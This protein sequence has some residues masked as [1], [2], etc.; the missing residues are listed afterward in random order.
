M[1]RLHWIALCIGLVCLLVSAL[2]ASAGTD[3]QV[4]RA[5]NDLTIVV[6][7]NT[8]NRIVAVSV[9]VDAGSKYD[10]PGRR[11][12]AR[13]T[14]ELLVYGTRDMSGSE[15]SEVIDASGVQLGTR[16]T[17]DYA[18]I[19]VTALDSQFDLALKVL[20][21]VVQRPTFDKD[22]VLLAQRLA[23][24][25]L[26]R[27]L[28]DPFARTYMKLNEVLARGHPYASPVI[29]TREGIDAITRKDVALFHA[30]RYSASGTVVAA[31]GN[32]LADEAVKRIADLFSEYPKSDRRG[33]RFPSLERAESATFE[34]HKA[35]P[36]GYLQLGFLAPALGA[37]DYA[38][39]RVLGAVLGDGAA[40]RLYTS[41][42]VDGAGLS[43]VVGA[44]YPG[45]K[46]AGRMVVYA[47]TNQVDLT[48]DILERE[49][50][51][52]RVERVSDEEL[53]RA[54]SRLMARRVLAEQRNLERA[55]RLARD[56][57][58]GLGVGFGDAHVRD[59][60]RV[61]ADDVLRVAQE[62][63]TSPVKV[64]LRPGSRGKKGI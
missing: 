6:S 55:R 11:G 9:L 4:H 16:T 30:E 13:L 50:E 1:K 42:G 39:V 5:D 10:P 23:R 45:R 14:N 47:A 22:A 62:Y 44:F 48:L 52:L 12:L 32:V 20:A 54:Q 26:E 61:D 36:Q 7:P 8:W 60:K 51:K 34:F 35:A 46:E 33:V 19:Y 56:V 24:E 21:D 64:L 18:E 2:S 31:V 40:S 57:L 37:K 53:G 17:E 63:L 49:I 28:D 15:L 58:L 27:E 3:A 38:A 25:E 59:I 41:L 29:G 43:E